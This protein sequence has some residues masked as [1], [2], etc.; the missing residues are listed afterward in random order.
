MTEICLLPVTLTSSPGTPIKR[1]TRKSRQATR[2]RRRRRRSRALLYRALRCSRPHRRPG[3]PGVRECQDAWA[4]SRFLRS[5]DRRRAVPWP[6]A[7]PEHIRPTR[8]RRYPPPVRG[9]VAASVRLVCLGGLLRPHPRRWSSRPTKLG[10]HR[11][12]ERRRRRSV[13][14]LTRRRSQ[15]GVPFVEPS[16]VKPFLG[17]TLVRLSPGVT[18]SAVAPRGLSPLRRTP[19]HLQSKVFTPNTEATCAGVRTASASGVAAAFREWA[20]NRPDPADL[21][22]PTTTNRPPGRP[23]AHDAD[24][25]SPLRPPAPNGGEQH[26]Q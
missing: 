11:R 4:R 17:V 10:R 19:R 26:G 15:G 5:T 20:A 24:V 8:Q 2:T 25:L 12:S 13:C 3:A 21:S 18:L 9:A 1:L 16:R 23:P 14:A 6:D 7:T 22:I